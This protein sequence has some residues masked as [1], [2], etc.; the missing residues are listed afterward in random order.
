MLKARENTMLR[1]LAACS[2][3]FVVLPIASMAQ[4]ASSNKPAEHMIGTI[5]AVDATS[6]AVTVKEDKTGTEKKVLVGNTRTLLKVEPGAKDLKN[7]TRIKADDLQAGDR[8]DVRGSKAEDDPN[9]IAARSV[10]LMTARDLQHAHQVEAAAWQHSTAGIVSSV[11]PATGKL[12]VTVATPAGKQPVTVDT[13]KTTEFTRYSVENPKQPAASELAQIQPGDQVRIIGTKSDDGATIT[14]EK[15]YSG[16]FRTING[17]VVS[18]S[19][20]GKSAVVKNLATKRPVQ[21]DLNDESKVRRLPS[22]MAMMLARRL[23]PN[24]HPAQGGERQPNGEQGQAAAENHE[25]AGPAN[26]ASRSEQ[27]GGYGAGGR[28]GM[29]GG[30]DV[31]QL[32]ERLPAISISDLKPGEAVVISGVRTD[33]SNPGLVAT[34]IIAGVEPILQSAPARSG[35]QS[36]GGDWGLGEMTVPQ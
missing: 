26:G 19:A 11:D 36:A 35:G 20:D 23:N 30:G 9:A 4:E 2:A 34:N 1:L 6:H 12:V 21:V 14:A 3:V 10:V 18:I 25:T 17:T 24:F 33:G 8:V 15:I 5:T 16:A 13:A 27:G 32:I 28:R 31:A 29:S 22:G 7:A